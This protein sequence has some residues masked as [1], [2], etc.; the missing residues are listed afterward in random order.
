MN[1]ERERPVWPR[2]GSVGGKLASFRLAWVPGK[3]V[4]VRHLRGAFHAQTGRP[5]YLLPSHISTEA[6][7]ASGWGDH[8][9]G[10]LKD[11]A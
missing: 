11:W 10:L 6:D 4:R 9:A 5:S 2:A 7:L 1:Q 8:V 3:S